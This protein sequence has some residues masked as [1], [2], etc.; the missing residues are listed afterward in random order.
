MGKQGTPPADV[1]FFHPFV[2]S[3]LFLALCSLFFT[4]GQQLCPPLFPGTSPGSAC[5][6]IQGRPLP[7]RCGQER[8][9]RL[10]FGLMKPRCWTSDS[11]CKFA[12]Q[13]RLEGL[14][15]PSTSHCAP[16]RPGWRGTAGEQVLAECA[17]VVG[18]AQGET[19]WS[20]GCGA[21]SCLPSPAGGW[22]GGSLDE[23]LLLSVSWRS[24]DGIA[25]PQDSGGRWEH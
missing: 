21:G 24:P 12:L 13:Q 19:G 15:G 1:G 7:S 22:Y 23:G 11:R 3:V 14:Q 6:P 2:P 4:P 9:R 10:G 8:S 20:S 18:G 17:A 25:S 16:A 5:T